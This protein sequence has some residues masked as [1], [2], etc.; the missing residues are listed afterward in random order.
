MEELMSAFT[1]PDWKKVREFRKAAKQGLLSEIEFKFLIG[2]ISPADLGDGCN[3][4]EVL[5]RIPK[6]KAE[7]VEKI[8][9][10]GAEP[11]VGFTAEEEKVETKPAKSKSKSKKVRLDDDYEDDDDDEDEDNDRPPIDVIC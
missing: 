2:L 11:P 3:E 1:T 10:I 4:N 7:E 6:D 9:T 8:V 5:M